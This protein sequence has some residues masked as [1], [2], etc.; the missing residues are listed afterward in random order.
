MKSFILAKLKNYSAYLDVKRFKQTSYKEIMHLIP[1]K[2]TL[3]KVFRILGYAK[4]HL[5]GFLTL[6]T[7]SILSSA[8]VLVN[9]YLV[10]ILIDDVLST[11]DFEMLFLILSLFLIVFVVGSLISVA[12]GYLSTGLTEKVVLDVKRDLFRHLE[13]L[14]LG[15]YHSKRVGDILSRLNDDVYGVEGFI[16]L[17]INNIMLDLLTGTFILAMCLKLN[18]KVTLATLLFIPFYIAVQKYYGKKVRKKRRRL[19]RKAADILSFLQE[20]L[21]EIKEIQ[22]FSRENLELERYTKQTR[23]LINLSMEMALLRGYSFMWVSYLSFIPLFIVLLYGGFNVMIGAMTV[24]TLIALYTYLQRFFGPVSRLGNINVAFQ[25]YMVSVDRVFEFMNIKPKVFDRPG[26]IELKDPKGS[27]EF[28]SVYF[29]Y[30][31]KNILQ[32]VSFKINPSEKIGIVGPSGVGKSTIVDLIPRFVEPRKG[33]VLI[34]G[35]DNRNIKLNYLKKI[36]GA[37]GADPGL[38][39]TT[40]LENI[41]FGR[42][43]ATMDEV[44]K[45]AKL[46]DAHNFIV[47]LKDGY[48]TVI[49]ERG[50][51]LSSGQKQRIA[52]ARMLLKDPK[53]I[54]LDEATSTIDAESSNKIYRALDK[55]TKDKT[56]IIITHDLQLLKRVDRIFVLE[57][58]KIAESGK[59]K[60]LLN[61]KQEFYRM[62]KEGV[63]I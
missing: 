10:K 12:Y 63:I 22:A 36:V 24:G 5:L 47:K 25:S 11:R 52:I 32:G 20:D 55:F 15:F 1:Q 58:G 61:K 28:K 34:D 45:V 42:P 33:A 31:K 8:I 14:H 7:L 51:N 16:E 53:I 13:K 19:R 48:S 40:I 57:N 62:F 18:A 30:N 39:N 17:L 38:F 4:S 46:A 23:K 21:S 59:F 60:E 56:T 49:G 35:I 37:V 50:E 6:F 54:I 26:A 29:G 41:K 27:I 2:E 43:D 3:K 9:P 44:I